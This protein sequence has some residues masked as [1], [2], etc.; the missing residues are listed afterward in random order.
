[1]SNDEKIHAMMK[2]WNTAL[3]AADKRLRATG[4]PA[5]S[6]SIAIMVQIVQV[7]IPML[8]LAASKTVEDADFLLREIEKTISH[9]ADTAEKEMER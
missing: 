7:A 1:M 9:L 2:R 4:L 3:E 5:G 6:A 8:C